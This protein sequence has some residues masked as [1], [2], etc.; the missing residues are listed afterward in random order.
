MF[1]WDLIKHQRCQIRIG[2]TPYEVN[3]TGIPINQSRDPDDETKKTPKAITAKPTRS[4]GGAL[5]D[6]YFLGYTIPSMGVSW[7]TGDNLIQGI[8]DQVVG[9]SAKASPI[10]AVLKKLE[11]EGGG[12]QTGQAMREALI[13]AFQN[14]KSTKGGLTKQVEEALNQVGGL[15]NKLGDATTA[16]TRLLSSGSVAEWGGIKAQTPPSISVEVLFCNETTGVYM[17]QL[18]PL[19]EAS[20]F[21]EVMGSNI[22]SGP[23]GYNGM[24]F[25]VK[26]MEQI[27]DKKVDS[28]HSLCLWFNNDEKGQNVD[29]TLSSNIIVDLDRLLIIDSL[30]IQKSEQLFYDP[31]KAEFP[32]YKWIKASIKFSAACPVPGKLQAGRTSM[33][34]FYG[35]RGI[36]VFG[37][38]KLTQYKDSPENLRYSGYREEK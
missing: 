4:R 33:H 24:G 23:R 1:E 9:F 17:G 35:N 25:G 34:D 8:V 38:T 15:F 19:I 26:A 29:Q 36:S 32:L 14:V 10:I 22:V 27:L 28:L 37:E 2:S 13:G 12:A 30:S 20:N 5:I 21:Q 18:T 31:N 16:E 3:W 7:T 11:S 6:C